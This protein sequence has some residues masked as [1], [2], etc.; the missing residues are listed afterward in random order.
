MASLKTELNLSWLL[1]F[2]NHILCRA[3]TAV[4]L[5]F[6]FITYLSVRKM[7]H[8]GTA[9]PLDIV[10]RDG[11]CRQNYERVYCTVLY[12]VTRLED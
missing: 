1:R 8:L 6:T 11:M 4:N 2:R 12:L 3:G 9:L 7:S 10:I 5:R